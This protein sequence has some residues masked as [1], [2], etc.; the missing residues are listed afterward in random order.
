MNTVALIPPE[1]PLAQRLREAQQRLE[2][3]R[4][5]VRRL[6]ESIVQ[7]LLA[8]G[9]NLEGMEFDGDGTFVRDGIRNRL[10]EI[11][12]ESLM[13]AIRIDGL[14]W[15]HL[16]D[17]EGHTLIGEIHTP[18]DDAWARQK[19]VNQHR[20]HNLDAY[21]FTPYSIDE[22][23]DPKSVSS[24]DQPGPFQLSE[25]EEQAT[26]AAMAADRIMAFAGV[27]RKIHTDEEPDD[28]R[29]IR[30]QIN[31]QHALTVCE[32]VEKN[33]P[34]DVNGMQEDT[35][36]LEGSSPSA[37]AEEKDPTDVTAITAG[38]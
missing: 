10:A 1:H 19:T 20:L 9:R 14:G 12:P 30:V 38:R 23:I 33:I 25:G 6:K 7:Q 18:L 16:Y 2:T 27:A 15:I 11:L 8:W 22:Y 31:L 34:K 4:E 24:S 37:N 3:Q 26:R 29:N 35:Y 17:M 13:D 21:T 36:L 5:P 32:W 28:Y